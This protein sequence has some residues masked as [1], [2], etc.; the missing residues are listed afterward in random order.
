MVHF[1]MLNKFEGTL[2]VLKSKEQTSLQC[3]QVSKE[4]VE[5][6]KFNRLSSSI[7]FLVNSRYVVRYILANQTRCLISVIICLVYINKF[8]GVST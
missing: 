2:V 5:L 6:Q 3:E 7:F 8:F 4:R 1:S